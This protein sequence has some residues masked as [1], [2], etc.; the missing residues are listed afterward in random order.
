MADFSLDTM[1]REML[2][3]I[4]KAR[5]IVAGE[6]K[7]GNLIDQALGVLHDVVVNLYLEKAHINQLIMMTERDKPKTQRNEKSV[8]LA[9]TNWKRTLTEAEGYVKFFK[10]TKWMS[11]IHR[12]WGRLYDATGK[13]ALA[14]PHYKTA[15]KLAKQDPE[16]TDQG[17]PRWLEV[18]GFLA[19]AYIYSG[20]IAKGWTA[21]KKIYD[22]FDSAEAADLKKND[23]ST[24][25][26]WKSG[27]PI[28]I[29]QAL[30]IKKFKIDMNEF[31]AWLEMAEKLLTPPPTV[32]VWVDF[33]FRKNEIAA[34]KREL[35]LS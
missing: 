20:Q 4:A 26:I 3:Q 31:K 21:A 5:E 24:W 28:R 11:R 7:T 16:Y 17:V 25:A 29:G 33:Q 23:Y 27:I 14:I 9:I 1:P 22:R 2:A 32:K 12:Y 30:R 6:T 35:K 15:I 8:K 19:S 13:S 34:I 10:L 18:E